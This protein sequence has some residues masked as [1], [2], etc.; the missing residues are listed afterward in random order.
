MLVTNTPSWIWI[1]IG[2]VNYD[3]HFVPLLC[4]TL[5]LTGATVC[6][7]L[8]L[9]FLP[10]SISFPG[11]LGSI[12]TCLRGSANTGHTYLGYTKGHFSTCQPNFYCCFLPFLLGYGA[13]IFVSLPNCLE[14]KLKAQQDQ[15]Q[16]FWIST[17][18][19]AWRVLLLNHAGHRKNEPLSQGKQKFHKISFHKMKVSIKIWAYK[20][21]DVIGKSS[22]LFFLSSRMAKCVD[23]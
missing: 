6:T 5:K 21:T 8:S 14:K 20:N 12:F 3:K 17:D 19:M 15:S 4:V 7:F 10:S 9:V 18:S 16:V 22:F 13:L 11:Q 2:I 1:V 23:E